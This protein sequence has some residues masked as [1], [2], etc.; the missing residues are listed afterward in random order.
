M[1]PFDLTG[2]TA[3]VTGAFSG[4]GLHFAGLLAAH[5]AKVALVGRRLE[6]GTQAAE[7]LGRALGR[8][9][10]VRAWAMDVT[11]AASVADG[12][13]QVAAGLGVP[14]IVVNN[15]G[16]VKRGPSLELSEA[17][18]QDVLDVNLSGVFRVA[19]AGAREMVRAGMPG[20]IINIASILGLRVRTQVLP[21]TT[22]KAAVVQMTKALALEWAEHG[23]R[24]NA[25]A[26][27]YFETDINRD[28]LRSPVG[29]AILSRVPQKR[30]GQLAELDGPMLL[31]ASDASSYMT[32]A[33]I[34]VDGGHL[35]STL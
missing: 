30:A 35:V 2:R 23:I 31:L 11:D 21:Y 5:G 17:D 28:L 3:L 26:P 9:A 19:Q 7:A 25:I 15:A 13:A 18:W 20:S 12:F 8:P 22:T 29:Q 24:V 4:L 33:V 14:D 1:T 34:P 32:G 27:G 6:L 16:T 10:D